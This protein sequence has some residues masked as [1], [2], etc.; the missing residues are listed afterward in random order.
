MLSDGSRLHDRYTVVRLIGQGGMGAVYLCRDD[1]LAEA[2]WALKELHHEPQEGQVLSKLQHPQLPMV[3][4]FFSENG[5][6]YLVREYV[7]GI[8]LAEKVEQDGPL[9][10]AVTLARPY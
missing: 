1:R 10:E 6:F 9:G 2:T 5:R 3:V 7:P 4:D 8:N